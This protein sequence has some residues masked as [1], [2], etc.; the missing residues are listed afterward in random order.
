VSGCKDLSGIGRGDVAVGDEHVDGGYAGCFV[1]QERCA[2]SAKAFRFVLQRD[3]VTLVD[4]DVVRFLNRCETEGVRLVNCLP[5]IRDWMSREQ[6]RSQGSRNIKL[7]GVRRA[8][9]PRF[10]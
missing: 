9:P 6:N 1:T 4:V 5:Y 10:D 7:V 3:E 2:T 8:P